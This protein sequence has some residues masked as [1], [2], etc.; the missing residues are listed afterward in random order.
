VKGFGL[1][2]HHLGLAVKTEAAAISFLD[3]NGYACG[4]RI[5]DPEQNVNLRMCTSSAG[6]WVELITPGEGDGPLTPILKRYDQLFYHSCYEV[7][8]RTASLAALREAGLRVL[9]V[10]DAKPSLLFGGRQVSFYNIA[11]FG[12]VELLE[13]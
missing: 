5:Y 13:P 4:E 2:F 1:A 7:A 10:A 9:P 12:L 3:G 8:D 6:P 11:G